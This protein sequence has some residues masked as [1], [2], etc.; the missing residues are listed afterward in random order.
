MSANSENDKSIVEAH[1]D[2]VTHIFGAGLSLAAI[3]SLDRVDDE[4]A[5][6][7]RDALAALDTAAA[8]LRTAAFAHLLQQS[9]GPPRAGG[10]AADP[11]RPPSPVSP[12]RQ[13]SLRLRRRP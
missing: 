5:E 7:L 10:P 3:L 1:D 4:V 13:R 11:E 8:D 12:Q 2:A 9:E 6:R